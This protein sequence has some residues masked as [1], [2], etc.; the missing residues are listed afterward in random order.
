MEAESSKEQ[1]NTP[2]SKGVIDLFSNDF[3]GAY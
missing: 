1:L 3:Y 2:H